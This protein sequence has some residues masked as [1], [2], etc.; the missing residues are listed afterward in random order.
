MNN[1]TIKSYINVKCMDCCNYRSISPHWTINI[2]RDI[3]K[4]IEHKINLRYSLDGK[5][6]MI[7]RSKVNSKCIELLE[8]SNKYAY[9]VEQQYC[10]TNALFIIIKIYRNRRLIYKYSWYNNLLNF[11][12]RNGELIDFINRNI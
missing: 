5:E 12:E 1:I 2:N 3:V 9:D 10:S 4:I 11:Q 6:Y 7:E 8:L